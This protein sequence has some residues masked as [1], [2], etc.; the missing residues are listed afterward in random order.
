MLTISSLAG[1]SSHK[2]VPLTSEDTE[3]QR[4]CM[5]DLMSQKEGAGILLA[6]E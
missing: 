1:L 4:S 5:I 6:Q 3:A 2:F